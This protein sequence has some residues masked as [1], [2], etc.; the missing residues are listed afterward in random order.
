MLKSIVAAAGVAVWT[1]GAAPRP[2]RHRAAVAAL[3]EGVVSGRHPHDGR[4]LCQS[5]LVAVMGRQA[6]ETG[7]R[8]AW[9]DLVSSPRSPA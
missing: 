9:E 1:A 2:N 8:V 3:L 4:I 5:T 6:A 7:S